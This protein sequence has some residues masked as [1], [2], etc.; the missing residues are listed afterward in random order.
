MNSDLVLSVTVPALLLY[1][2]SILTERALLEE[3]GLQGGER[4][5][6]SPTY[7]CFSV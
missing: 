2:Q 1:H 5:V 3:G 6:Q 7:G 4:R